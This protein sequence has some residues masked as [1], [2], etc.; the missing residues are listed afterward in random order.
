MITSSSE[1]VVRAC[2]SQFTIRWPRYI[3]PLLYRSIKTSITESYKSGSI[4]KR[5]RSQSHEAPSLRSCC[6]MIPP[7]LWVH[8]QQYSR[9]SSLVR[10]LLLIPL[11][12]SIATT[13][14]SVAMDAWSVPGTQQASLPSIRAF[15]TRIS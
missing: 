14:A 10:S 5:V 1:T 13:F 3:S 2:G 4:V 6:K 9:N 15:R 8:S 12:L 7:Y 11:S